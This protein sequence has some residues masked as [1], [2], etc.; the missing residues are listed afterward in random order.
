M[1]QLV[2]VLKKNEEAIAQARASSIKDKSFKSGV[3]PII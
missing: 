1:Q 2:D 3:K